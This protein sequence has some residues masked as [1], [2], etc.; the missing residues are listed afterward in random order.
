MV[1]HIHVQLHYRQELH[2]S[3]K[4]D[5]R[6]VIHDGEAKNLWHNTKHL[7]SAENFELK[8]LYENVN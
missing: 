8:L 7:L 4:S 2:G 3:F 5:P 1:Y 6:C